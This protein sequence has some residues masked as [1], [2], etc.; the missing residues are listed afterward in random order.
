MLTRNLLV[1]ELLCARTFVTLGF[2]HI[3]LV[4]F[5]ATTEQ[6][7]NLSN[8]SA[9]L[10]VHLRASHRGLFEFV[11]DCEVCSNGKSFALQGNILK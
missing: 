5:P 8:T 3:Q 1:M 11:F 4:A 7:P 10:T 9:R 2:A 6:T